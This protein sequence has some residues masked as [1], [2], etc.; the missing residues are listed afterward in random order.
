MQDLEQII[1]ELL[2]REGSRYTHHPAD[3]GGPTKYGITQAALA[4]YRRRPVTEQEVRD[5]GEPEARLIYRNNYLTRIQLH[6]IADPFVMVLA[7]D[8]AVNHG[9]T[10]A[11]QWLQQ[12]VGVKDDGALGP[13][14]ERAINACDPAWLYRRLLA[15]RIE[16]Y[17]EIITRD[18]RLTA[19]VRAGYRLQAENALGW[20]RRAASFL[21]T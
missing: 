4:E 11:V 7:F 10:R 3:R 5:L 13:V 9:R 14:T 21:E 19:A 6:R 8:C 15:R 18:P 1:G 17:G 20:L 12:I 2:V 16:F